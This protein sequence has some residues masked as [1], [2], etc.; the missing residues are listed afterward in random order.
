MTNKLDVSP[1]KQ[2]IFT[3]LSRYV[4]NLNFNSHENITS[5]N[6][7]ILLRYIVNENSNTQD[8]LN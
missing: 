1:C 7:V 8:M 3:M 4:I 5:I 2:P 6:I